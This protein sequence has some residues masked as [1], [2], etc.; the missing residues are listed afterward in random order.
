[1]YFVKELRDC[2]AVSRTHS[3]ICSPI[4]TANS[5][6]IGSEGRPGLVCTL[7]CVFDMTLSR[8]R[9]ADKLKNLNND[10]TYHKPFL[11]RELPKCRCSC[12]KYSRSRR[13]N[14]ICSASKLDSRSLASKLPHEQPEHGDVDL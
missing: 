13:L 9:L 14:W 6:G 2:L 5:L 7:L 4:Q 10:R 1:M 12:L 11:V 8:E 3:G